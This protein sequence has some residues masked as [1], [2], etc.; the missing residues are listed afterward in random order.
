MHGRMDGR[1]D[2][3]FD[4]LGPGPRDRNHEERFIN[5]PGPGPS[6]PVGPPPHAKDP[7]K[8]I[9]REKVPIFVST[10]H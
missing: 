5:R 2:G 10:S 7:E 3:P 6:E 8:P 1:R 4:R 9:D